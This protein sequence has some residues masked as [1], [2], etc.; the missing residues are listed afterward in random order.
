MRII[1]SVLFIVFGFFFG[2]S[3]ISNV[4]EELLLPTMPV[5]LSESSGAIFFND[6]LITHTDSG[7]ESKLY[8]LDITSGLVTR[9]VTIS[10]ATNIDWEDV[11]QDESYIYIGDIGNNEGNRANLK[12]YK[13]SKADYLNAT[14]VTAQIIAFSYATQLD[15]T[16]NTNNNEWDAEALVSFNATNLILFSKNWVTGITKGYLIPKTPGNYSIN[17]LTTPLNS[18]GLIS[19]GTYNNLSGKLYLVGYTNFLQPFVWVSENFNGSDIFSGINTKTLL[20]SLGQEQ[21]EAIAFTNEN[22]YLMTSESFSVS[23]GFFTVSDDAKL[24]SFATTDTLLAIQNEN[25][26]NDVVAYP[27]PVFYYLTIDTLNSSSIEL[28]DAKAML[29]YKGNGNKVDMSHFSN[30]LYMVKI[31]FKDGTFSIKK[32]IKK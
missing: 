25:P 30:G 14:T 17:P 32:V 24:I 12:I 7:G 26:Q 31:N 16:S 19:G 28:F 15:F 6:K 2:S 27:N 4:K 8:E 18:G 21:I 20:S 22:K 5:N 11:T 9:T 29:I 13:I 10:N 1:F 23:V 3:Q